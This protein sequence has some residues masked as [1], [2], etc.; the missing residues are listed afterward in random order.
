MASETIFNK[1]ISIRRE[2]FISEEDLIERIHFYEEQLNNCR[3]KLVAL[4]ASNPRDIIPEE[5]KDQSIDYLF[6]KVSDILSELEEYT[7]LLFKCEM[8]LDYLR[9]TG[10]DIKETWSI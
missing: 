7:V 1:T 4:T 9:D 3:A 10:V 2:I 5:W 6:N 8:F